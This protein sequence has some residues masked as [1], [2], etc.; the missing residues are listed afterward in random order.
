MEKRRLQVEKLEEKNAANNAKRAEETETTQMETSSAAITESTFSYKI[1]KISDGKRIHPIETKSHSTNTLH[2]DHHAEFKR[3]SSI[4]HGSHTMGSQQSPRT[5]GSEIYEGDVNSEIVINCAGSHPSKTPR[6]DSFHSPRKQAV[7]ANVKSAKPLSP[8]KPQ[9]TNDEDKEE[10]ELE[11][12]YSFGCNEF[13]GVDVIDKDHVAHDIET[14]HSKDP[15][16]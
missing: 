7:S 4:I 2:N 6:G 15:H 13:A 5:V 12:E 1:E 9:N 8:V 16:D 10:K 14:P 11:R 3:A